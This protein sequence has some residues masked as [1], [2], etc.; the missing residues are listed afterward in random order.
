MRTPFKICKTD[1][2]QCLVFGFANV[3]ISKRTAVAEGGEQFFDLQEDSIPPADL[4]AAAYEHVLEFREADDDHKGPATGQLVE[5]IIFTPDKLEKFAADPVTG[6]VNQED[7]AVLKRLFP[8]RWWV[9]YKM[10]KASFDMVKSGKFTMF[11]IAG[12]ADREE[13]KD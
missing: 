5:S 2:D 9:G 4:E 11:S 6:E 3:S 1:E 12:E 10:N 7:L 8:C 13:V